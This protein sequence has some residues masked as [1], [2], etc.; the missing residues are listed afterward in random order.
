MPTFRVAR[1]LVCSNSSGFSLSYKLKKV[2]LLLGLEHILENEA[3]IILQRLEKLA[4]YFRTN[5]FFENARMCMQ[6]LNEILAL[7]EEGI[8]NDQSRT[9]LK[10][11]LNKAT[12]CKGDSHY[13]HE[14]RKQSTELL[15]FL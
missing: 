10:A 5:H 11:Q 13:V 14:L 8:P 2:G 1:S 7:C 12:Q 4:A 9:L 15:R 6:V 3:Y